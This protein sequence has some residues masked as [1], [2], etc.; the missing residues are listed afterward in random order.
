MLIT[1]TNAEESIKEAVSSGKSPGAYEARHRRSPGPHTRWL[2]PRPPTAGRTC[3]HPVLDRASDASE[4]AR[5]TL[6]LSDSA[7]IDLLCLG[8]CQ[9]SSPI[10]TAWR[11]LVKRAA[12]RTSEQDHP[13]GFVASD[14]NN[15]AVEAVLV[16]SAE[17]ASE[18]DR[19][20]L[21]VTS[22]HDRCAS[23]RYPPVGTCD[24][25]QPA[26]TTMCG[27]FGDCWSTEGD[28]I[29]A[30]APERLV[31]A[32]QAPAD[33]ET[34]FSGVGHVYWW[35]WSR[36]ERPLKAGPRRL[37]LRCLP[38]PNRASPSSLC[39]FNTGKRRPLGGARAS[40]PMPAGQ[41]EAA[42]VRRKVRQ[43][44]LLR[45]RTGRRP[46]YPREGPARRH[47]FGRPAAQG[48]T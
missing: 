16:V 37:F 41:S 8:H 10:V 7:R 20:D 46:R 19:G 6:R 47:G 43:A 25:G 29:T 40:P 15:V 35:G 1:W 26:R 21:A 48:R 30:R 12:S 36:S 17:V 2:F 38:C 44:H 22:H 39:R 5:A 13:A 24:P 45:R 4:I 14:L 9:S 34:L 32:D 11:V 3:S 33:V 23:T 31:V 27:R 28:A 42:P 18:V